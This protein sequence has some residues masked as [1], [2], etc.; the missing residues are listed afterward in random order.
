MRFNNE[1]PLDE[2]IGCRE[3][4]FWLGELL[5]RKAVRTGMNHCCDGLCLGLIDAGE[6]LE[7]P[8]YFVPAFR[9]ELT[10]RRRYQAGSFLA[11]RAVASMALSAKVFPC[12][13]NVC[14]SWDNC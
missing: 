14:N 1:Q 7:D 2:L 10:D 5:Q 8:R 6:F 11:I 3:I 9:K 4:E 13:I 12:S